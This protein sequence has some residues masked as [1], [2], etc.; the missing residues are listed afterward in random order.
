MKKEILDHMLAANK[1]LRG[2]EAAG[3]HSGGWDAKTDKTA[4]VKGTGPDSEIVGYIDRATLEITWK[5]GVT[6]WEK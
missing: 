3:Y 6:P 4:I 1:Q 5:E 2:L